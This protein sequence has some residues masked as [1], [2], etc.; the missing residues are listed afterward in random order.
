MATDLEGFAVAPSKMACTPALALFNPEVQQ[1]RVVFLAR[2]PVLT[3]AECQRVCGIVEEFHARERGGVW[4]TVRKA[5]VKTTDVAVEVRL[6][7]LSLLLFLFFCSFLQTTLLLP[8][9][10]S[11][12]C[13]F[14][15]FC[16]GS[17]VTVRLTA[18][19]WEW[20]D[21]AELRPWLREL[22]HTRLY[23]LAA[24]AYPRLADGST[25]T[26]PASGKSRLRVHDA[27]I[28]R[29]VPAALP[30]LWLL[31]SV[32]CFESF[33]MFLLIS[34]RTFPVCPAVHSV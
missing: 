14:T 22:L 16:L 5:T 18:V 17:T 27:F 23:P 8:V 6:F 7:L 21:I 32:P 11:L 20:Q 15:Q 9:I 31:A 13:D 1:R 12:S 10:G 3:P 28:V 2:Q 19:G 33:V 29:Y 4:S 26:D 25:L 30:S 24:A 34:E